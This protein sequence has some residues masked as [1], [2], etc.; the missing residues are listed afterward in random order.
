MKKIESH[1]FSDELNAADIKNELETYTSGD[2]MN[3]EGTRVGGRYSPSS[4]G[5][6]DMSPPTPPM[7]TNYRTARRRKGIPHRAPLGS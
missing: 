2:S 7:A 4:N 3:D 5:Y 1:R 6:T